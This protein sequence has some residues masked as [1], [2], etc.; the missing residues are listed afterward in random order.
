[1]QDIHKNS[2]HELKRR[3]IQVCY[4][5]C[6]LRTW[7]LDRTSTSPSEWAW[8]RPTYSAAAIYL[9]LPRYEDTQLTLGDT[10]DDCCI[11]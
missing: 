2:S 11:I 1:M 4:Q 7:P 3:E 9:T 6:V 8:I 10:K 5:E